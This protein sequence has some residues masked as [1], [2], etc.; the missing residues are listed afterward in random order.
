MKEEKR[1]NFSYEATHSSETQKTH[2]KKFQNSQLEN[3]ID[4]II[5]KDNKKST[6]KRK[7]MAQNTWD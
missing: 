4:K 7:H 1:E 6:K 2:I 3:L 5:K